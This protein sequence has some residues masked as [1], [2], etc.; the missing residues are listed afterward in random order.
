MDLAIQA[1]AFTTAEALSKDI[2]ELVPPIMKHSRELQ[3]DP[4]H[5]ASHQWLKYLKLTPKAEKVW[6]G[7]KRLV[8][9]PAAS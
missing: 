5:L 3:M 8:P 4:E 7:N 6:E 1:A 2:K 9:K